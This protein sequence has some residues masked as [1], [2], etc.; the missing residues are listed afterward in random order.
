MH[1]SVC[2]NAL[3]ITHINA[4]VCR[5][6]TDRGGDTPGHWLDLQVLSISQPLR[7]AHVTLLQKRLYPLLCNSAL[8]QTL[9]ILCQVRN[10]GFNWNT[11]VV[12]PSNEEH[13]DLREVLKTGSYMIDGI[14]NQRWCQGAVG[15]IN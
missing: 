10:A 6:S 9:C 14:L 15:H 11:V 3:H 1:P 4:G 8:S 2:L 12:E 7:P 13:V 5:Q